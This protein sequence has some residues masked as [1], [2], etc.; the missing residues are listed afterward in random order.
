MRVFS[1]CTLLLELL[2]ANSESDSDI[3]RYIAGNVTVL[4]ILSYVR[5]DETLPFATCHSC[6]RNDYHYCDVAL[7]HL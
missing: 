7:L 5:S 4:L 3:R 1:L 2:G 6:R